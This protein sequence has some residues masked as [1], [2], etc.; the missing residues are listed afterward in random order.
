[1]LG[2][3]G[4]GAYSWYFTVIVLLY[5]YHVNHVYIT[6]N[7]KIYT[8]I[9]NKDTMLKMLQTFIQTNLLS[10]VQ[11]KDHGKDEHEKNAR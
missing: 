4:G 9:K 3:E 7:D 2:A 8:K 6:N 1:M 5:M 10:S 11:F